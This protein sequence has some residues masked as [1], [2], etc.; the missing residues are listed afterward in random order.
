M[1]A[2]QR[3]LKTLP[4]IVLSIFAGAA[5]AETAAPPATDEAHA[6]GTVTHLAGVLT[7]RRAGASKI[8]ATSSQIESGD[9]LI[10]E[11]NSYAR[12]KFI[13]NAEIVLRPA[14]ELE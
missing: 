3:L 7:V 9:T 4:I 10:T 2:M 1:I 8:L 6:V 14:T 13:D 5:R 12:I 11:R